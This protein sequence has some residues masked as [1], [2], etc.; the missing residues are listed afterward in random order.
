M[1]T[2][3]VQQVI[4][5]LA[6]GKTVNPK[7][8]KVPWLNTE[9]KLLLAKRDAILRRYVRF[10][11]RHLLEKFFDISNIAEEKLEM[12]R[13]AFMYSKVN[14]V[15]DSLIRNF[16]RSYGIWVCYLGLVT[17]YMVL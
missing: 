16:G 3:N 1:L 8:K 4:H 17:H 11:Q 9:H 14:D 7:T 5:L 10:C 13:Y 12:A 2:N 6:A 15:L